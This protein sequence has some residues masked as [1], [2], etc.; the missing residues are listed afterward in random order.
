MHS[1][2]EPGLGRRVAPRSRTVLALVGALAVVAVAVAAPAGAAAGGPVGPGETTHASGQAETTHT[3]THTVSTDARTTTLDRSA[4]DAASLDAPGE[5]VTL[6][7]IDADRTRLD[8]RVDTEGDATLGLE[9]WTR[10]GDDDERAAFDSLAEDVAADPETYADEFEER[11]AST[12]ADASA[13][14]G[15]EMTVSNASVETSTQAVPT[16]Y[17]VLAYEVEWTGF[18]AASGDELHVGDAIDGYV[19]EDDA[20][21]T[22][23]W[24]DAYEA[25]SVEPDPDDRADGRA[26]WNGEETDFVTGE[27]RLVLETDDDRSLPVP[28][29]L[30]LGGL[31][32]VALV[33]A[34]AWRYRRGGTGLPGM[35]RGGVSRGEPAGS[36][37]DAGAGAGPPYGADAATGPD[38]PVSGATAGA[39]ASG[40]AAAEVDPAGD[41]A[42]GGT[43]DDGEASTASQV[44]GPPADLRSNEELVLAVLDDHGGRVRQQQVVA[45]LD[46]TEAKTSKVVTSMREAGTIEVFRIG[47]ENVLA[48]PDETDR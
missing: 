37:A 18:A 11:I 47:R 33:G 6:Q 7:E 23:H 40:D 9:L 1:R 48:H 36:G 28:G 19:L 39:D 26:T 8:V 17:G 13:A 34:G 3:S 21:L 14:T 38:P 4:T 22:I 2:R 29:A 35:G 5:L 30:A 10:L 15:R 41:A 24:P 46:W 20:R 45:D 31:V 16:E 44:A 42:A 12:A 27:P 43:A 32:L 25:S